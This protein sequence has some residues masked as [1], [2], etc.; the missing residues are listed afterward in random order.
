MR[1]RELQKLSEAV[2]A[3]DVIEPVMRAFARSAGLG[4][5]RRTYCIMR[6]AVLLVWG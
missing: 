3:N 2:L 5:G 4:G 6:S 1:A